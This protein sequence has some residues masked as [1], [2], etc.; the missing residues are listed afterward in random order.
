M[1]W[2]IVDDD[3]DGIVTTSTYRLEVPGGWLYR[4]EYG[5]DGGDVAVMLVFVP[6]PD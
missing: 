4:V 3:N 6:Y 2:E 1:A 5:P